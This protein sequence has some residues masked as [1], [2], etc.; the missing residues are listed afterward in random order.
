[1]DNLVVLHTGRTLNLFRVLIGLLG[2]LVLRKQLLQVLDRV[3]QLC[4]LRLTHLEL[5]IPLILEVVDIVLGDGQLILGVLQPCT[6]IVKEVGLDIMAA[7]RPHQLIV[8]LHDAHLKAVV[9]L[10]ELSVAL[11]DIFDEVVLGSHLVVMLL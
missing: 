4:G 5:L 9:L 11:L 3:L 1:M 8:Q 6:G 7:V 10:E 2:L